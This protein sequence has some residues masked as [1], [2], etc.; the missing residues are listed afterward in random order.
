MADGLARE[1]DIVL[2][3]LGVDRSESSNVEED[4]KDRALGEEDDGQ[5]GHENAIEPGEDDPQDVGEELGNEEISAAEEEHMINREAAQRPAETAMEE[6]TSE[7][8]GDAATDAIPQAKDGDDEEP[9]E[10]TK[11]VDPKDKKETTSGVR[12][13]LKSG[14]FGAGAPKPS[15]PPKVA[16]DT[17]S[18]ARLSRPSLAPVRPGTAA[19]KTTVPSTSKPASGSATTTSAAAR[20]TAASRAFAPTRPGANGNVSRPTA[21]I[22]TPSTRPRTTTTAS[23]RTTSSGTARPAATFATN[24]VAARARAGMTKPSVPT[25]ASGRTATRPTS[26]TTARPTHSATTSTLA[27]KPD[28]KPASSTTTA[29]RTNRPSV[30]STTSTATRAPMASQRTSTS[31]AGTTTGRTGVTRPLAGRA[32]MAPTTS[33]SRAATGVP[34]KVRAGSGP[35]AI[36]SGAK[37]VTELKA[38][39]EELEKGIADEKTKYEEKIAALAQEKVDLEESH[40]KALE[41]LR[42]ELAN[43][44]DKVGSDAEGKIAELT[45]LHETQ[46]KEA[47]EERNRLMMEM[48]SKLQKMGAEYSS[49][50]AQLQSARSQITSSE[51]EVSSLKSSLQTAQD[52]LSQLR[53]TASDRDT[54]FAELESSKA[55]LQTRLNE[56]ET[57]RN[58][59]EKKLVEGEE[60]AGKSLADVTGL[61]DKVKELEDQIVELENKLGSEKGLW[62]EEE[63]KWRET[64]AALEKQIEDLKNAGE[65]HAEE[66]S[67]ASSGA[68]ASQEELSALRIAHEQLTTTYAGLVEASSR[69]PEDIENLQRQLK[70]ATDKHEALLLEASSSTN[71]QSAELEAQIEKLRKEKKEKEKE[72]EEL[73]GTLEEVEQEVEL[74]KNTRRESEER[75]RQLNEI[76]A[77]LETEIDK[78]KAEFENRCA[79]AFEDAKR[80]ASEEHHKELASIRSELTAT[81][82][83]LQDAHAAELE[84]LKTSHSTT[85]ATFNADHSSRTSALELS[86]QAANAQVEQ[87]QVKL[88]SVSAER[89]ALAEELKRLKAELEGA[90]AKGNEVDPEIEA[91][92]KKVKAE[93]QHVSDE[94]AGALEMSEM[95]KAHFEQT[96]STIQEQQADE[97]RAAVEDREKQYSQEKAQYT[98]EVGE[99]RTEMQKLKIEL[100]DEKAE[101]ESALARLA[102]KLSAPST[103]SPAEIPSSPSMARLHEAHNAKVTELENEI[104]RLKAELVGKPF[105]ASEPV[106]EYEDDETLTF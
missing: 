99:L 97:V 14:V 82:S 84:S 19:T 64:K 81:H 73:K 78:S 26:S 51:T 13:V 62:K 105:N 46:L 67:R 63:V 17:A 33:S 75:E 32:S 21:T 91:E 69:H 45:A 104:A 9:V 59:L 57:I 42:A 65:G 58:S 90:S 49:I 85:L 77:G 4:E 8:N 79:A 61:G 50:Q 39:V 106:E 11:G 95:N 23:D 36:A 103:P 1:E 18:S 40:G 80:A 20:K 101:K 29:T 3:N 48:V 88:E 52:E 70:E 25:A 87:D 2:Q 30:T 92:L 41:E 98:S 12:K 76:I 74:L 71:D 28:T 35:S 38:K 89:D 56:L 54:A 96:L 24:T 22:A 72:V 6:V 43:A 10:K 31:A 34:P 94:L 27:R 37:E 83:Q 55:S 86:L 68:E 93:L 47:E 53:T 102:E 16:A 15:P 100:S 66:L 5:R 7:D 60:E 44:T